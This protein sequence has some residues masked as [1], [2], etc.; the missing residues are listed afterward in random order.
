LFPL[1]SRTPHRVYSSCPS[2]SANQCEF[3]FCPPRPPSSF[4]LQSIKGCSCFLAVPKGP[5]LK[6]F[7]WPRSFSPKFFFKG[8]TFRPF[9]Q[10]DFS[11]VR[12]TFFRSQQPQT[13][14]PVILHGGAPKFFSISLAF[15]SEDTKPV[16]LGLPPTSPFPLL[17]GKVA[18]RTGP[19]YVHFVVLFLFLVKSPCGKK[20]A[21]LRL[22]VPST[23]HFL[24]FLAKAVLTTPTRI[25]IGAL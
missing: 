5:Q 21:C 1:T 12:L 13:R 9:S 14:R 20:M 2:V 15:F 3:F 25:F 16:D 24:T 22:L 19:S 4:F 18:F 11:S 8:S 6:G 7:L 10:V 17:P 23:N